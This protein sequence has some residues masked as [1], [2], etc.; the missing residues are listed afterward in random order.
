MSLFFRSSAIA[1]HAIGTMGLRTARPLVCPPQLFPFIVARP[2]NVRGLRRFA[3][4][5]NCFFPQCAVFLRRR[6]RALA[7]LTPVA[8]IGREERGGGRRQQRQ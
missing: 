3:S 2:A 6:L 5:G 4:A 7:R 8:L 1:A